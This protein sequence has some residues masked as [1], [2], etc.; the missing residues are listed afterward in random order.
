M[1]KIFIIIMIMSFQYLSFA[2][3]V[4]GE[5]KNAEGCAS[6]GSINISLKGG[7][8]PYEFKWSNGATTE[9]IA[10]LSTMELSSCCN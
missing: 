9:D 2:Q 6:N 8:T 5:V 10:K 4:C 7:F 1:K 3:D